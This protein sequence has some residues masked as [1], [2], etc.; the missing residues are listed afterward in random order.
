MSWIDKKHA[1]KRNTERGSGDLWLGSLLRV[2]AHGCTV[3]ELALQ[4]PFT[5]THTALLT[6]TTL[7]RAV[8]PNPGLA[9]GN[10]GS[11]GGTSWS[12]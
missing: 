10:G 11:R 8:N 9:G 6:P 5:P 2:M 12:D 1:E 3:K 7:Q 4:V